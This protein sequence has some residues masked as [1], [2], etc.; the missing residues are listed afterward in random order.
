MCCSFTPSAIN[1]VF[2][3]MLLMTASSQASVIYTFDIA[4]NSPINPIQFSVSATDFLTQTGPLAITPFTASDTLGDSWTFTDGLINVAP[5]TSL[6]CFGIF[7]LPAVGEASTCGVT[8]NPPG[9]GFLFIFG[10]T[11]GP[12][13]LPANDG[14]LTVQTD[15]VLNSPSGVTFEG[16]VTTTMTVSS[17]PEPRTT[18][19]IFAGFMALLGLRSLRLGKY[20]AKRLARP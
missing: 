6:A 18:I 10:G 17:V 14:V 19:A 9:G 13:Y 11:G 12:I 5:M 7:A 8:T 2:F 3:S 20:F 4:T 1:K 15:Y 16:V